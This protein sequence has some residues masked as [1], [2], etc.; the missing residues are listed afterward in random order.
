MKLD[1]A[2]P[3]VESG[4]KGGSAIGFDEFMETI[5]QAHTRAVLIMPYGAECWLYG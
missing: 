3:A 2:T 5:E 4:D 1:G